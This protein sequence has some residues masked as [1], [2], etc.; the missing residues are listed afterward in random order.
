M[1]TMEQKRIVRFHLNLHYNS[2]IPVVFVKGRAEP[3]IEGE[4]W[5]YTT[6]GGFKIYYPSS[7]RKRGWSSMIYMHSTKRIVVGEKW[8]G[9]CK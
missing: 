3:K 7:Y 1:S 8:S 4:S 9:F 5:H 2:R 6:R